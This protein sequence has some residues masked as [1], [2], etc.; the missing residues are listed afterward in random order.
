[1]RR[2]NVF[3][4]VTLDGYFTGVGGDLDW[5]YRSSPDSEWDAFVGSNAAGGG[6]LVLGRV[7][8]DMMVAWWPTAEA[9]AAMP[10]VAAGMNR[11]EK[12]VFSRSLKRSDW[13]NTRVVAGDP[14]AEMRM[15]KAGSGADMTILGS[16]TIV[17][18][19]ASADLIDSYQFVVNPVVLGAGRSMF[20]GVDGPIGLRLNDS[21][22]FRNGRVVLSYERA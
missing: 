19:L 15:L 14:V 1:M 16:G 17:A 5:A 3:N 12:I 13:S 10:D 2:L 9:R 11:N 21:R 6:T 18:L 4:N 20:E 8:Y 7:T 22:A